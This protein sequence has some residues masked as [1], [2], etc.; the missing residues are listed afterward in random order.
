LY[1]LNDPAIPVLVLKPRLYGN[2]FVFKECFT[3]LKNPGESTTLIGYT[4]K[5]HGN[6]PIIIRARLLQDVI[7]KLKNCGRYFKVSVL[8]QSNAD[9][10]LVEGSTA[11]DPGFTGLIY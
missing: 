6:G 10:L 9:K 7:N 5:L 11:A 2:S 4:K 3:D 1:Y 8:P